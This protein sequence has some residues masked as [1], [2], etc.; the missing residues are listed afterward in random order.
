MSKKSAYFEL[1]RLDGKHDFKKIKK[2][3]STL[4]GVISVSVNKEIDNIAVDYDST[5]V[6]QGEIENYLNEMGFGIT[7]DKGEDHTMWLGHTV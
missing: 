2:E 3:L 4:S 5:G 7:S 1:I 6:S